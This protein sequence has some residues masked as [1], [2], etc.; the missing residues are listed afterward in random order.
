VAVAGGAAVVYGHSS[1]AALDLEA[2]AAGVDIS[3]LAAYEPLY[4]GAPAPPIAGDAPADLA[5]QLRA[6][7][8]ARRPEEA[9]ARFLAV[10]RAPPQ[11]VSQ[12]Q[13]G[14][15][16]PGMVALAHT[17]AYDVTLGN[18]GIPPVD[19]L[20]R[21]T[22]RTLALAGGASPPWAVE[23]VRTIAATVLS[24]EQR[25]LTGQHH[26]AADDVLVPVLH[27]FFTRAAS[28]HEHQGP[29]PR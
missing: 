29:Q 3:A 22:A 14:P 10:T 23:A 15:G 5:E 20:A 26:V 18:G 4:A 17:L 24:A 6:L 13:A 16:W 25:V 1:G 19:R 9:A 11:V 12:I 8:H 27:E 7:V 21:I 28:S 2:A